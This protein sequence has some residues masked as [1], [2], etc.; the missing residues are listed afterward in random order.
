MRREVSHSQDAQ[1]DSS[2]VENSGEVILVVQ[3]ET[4]NVP[5]ECRGALALS[6][7]NHYSR[8]C[9][10]QNA[11]ARCLVNIGQSAI[12]K[13]R[14]WGAAGAKRRRAAIYRGSLVIRLGGLSTWRIQ[15]DHGRVN[16]KTRTERG[17]PAICGSSDRSRKV[18]V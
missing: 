10:L 9:S 11:D 13:P 8:L 2:D 5:I 16:E 12:Q 3:R 14:F 15:T 17:R 7:A 18:T 4:Q 1:C 6:G